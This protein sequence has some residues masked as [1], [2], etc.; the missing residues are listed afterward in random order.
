MSL[1][2][3]PPENE[4]YTLTARWILPIDAPPL[5]H[6]LLTLQ[7]D[8][9]VAVE[10]QGARQA[11]LDFG[12]AAILPGLVNA[13]THLDLSDAAGKCPPTPDFTLW[14]RQVIAHRRA[15]SE[16]DKARAVAT[17]IEQCVRYGTTLVGDIAAGG[18]SW[19][20]LTRVPLHSVVFHELIGLAPDRAREALLQADR[21]GRHPD[22]DRRPGLSPHAPYSF[23]FDAARA[24]A[25]REVPVALH[26]LESAAE[27]ELLAHH[28]GPFV[29]FLQELSA[30][31]PEGLAPPQAWVD[32]L[33]DH[34]LFIHANFAASL[35]R[36]PR[37]VVYCPRTHAA[38][39][40]PPHPFRAMLARGTRVALGTDSLASNPD[41]DVL[42]EARFL[43][44]R[45]PDVPGDALL[46]MITL[47][48]AEALGWGT[49]AGSLTP[50]KAGDLIVAP[51][52]NTDGQAEDVVLG[53]AQA[54]RH[55]LFRGRWRS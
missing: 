22:A 47:S 51:L 46:R 29:P 31:A 6:G 27:A 5:P 50:G 18:V 17:G 15:Q 3:Q 20:A 48:G 32:L 52:D 44:A 11:D 34:A 39:G 55:V 24:I 10:P 30:W 40:H 19:D 53:S 45:Y 36:L 16:E 4:P 41:L 33:G 28:T 14:L 13:H 37:T 49:T 25:P 7:G 38:F 23:N 54:V 8:H 21:C 42:A 12:N 1:F 2:P 26:F 35:P 43:H 9:I